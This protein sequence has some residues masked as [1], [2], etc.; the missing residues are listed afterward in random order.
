M[1]LLAYRQCKLTVYYKVREVIKKLF[2][3]GILTEEVEKKKS[4]DMFLLKHSLS[5]S[6]LHELQKMSR[7]VL[8]I[9]L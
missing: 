5:N 6:S 2:A 1:E 3:I 4:Y 9:T 8:H 7:Q